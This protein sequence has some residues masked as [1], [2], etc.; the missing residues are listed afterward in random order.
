MVL[1]PRWFHWSHGGSEQL[2][3]RS[4]RAEI[5]DE[6]PQLS[7]SVN[8]SSGGSD[9]DN[10]G[11]YTRAAAS[12]IGRRF[13]HTFDF[14][15]PRCEWCVSWLDKLLRFGWFSLDGTNER[16]KLQSV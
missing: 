10:D 6:L 16:A 2:S 1:D 7:G 13:F 11:K 14:S 12:R 9:S 3:Y 4:G 15:E 5:D 8:A